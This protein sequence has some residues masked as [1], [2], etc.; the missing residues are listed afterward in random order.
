VFGG[1]GF[2]DIVRNTFTSLSVLPERAN[3]TFGPPK[4]SGVGAGDQRA[5]L[6]GD[7]TGDGRLDADRAPST[8][9]VFVDSTP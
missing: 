2:A 1:D 3:G 8:F 4:L 6:L 7:L 9:A 5:T